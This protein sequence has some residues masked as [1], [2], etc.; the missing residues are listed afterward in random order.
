ML[1]LILTAVGCAL[2]LAGCER[3]ME[4]PTAVAPVSDPMAAATTA[5][6]EQPP[7]EAGGEPRVMVYHCGPEMRLVAEFKGDGMW[8][9]LPEQ[10]LLLQ[11][12]VS[13]SGARYEA[14]GV[15]FWNK[16]DNA[17]LEIEGQPQPQCVAEPREAVWEKAKLAG[18]DFRAIGQEPGWILELYPERVVLLLDYGQTRI[19]APSAS[20]INETFGSRFDLEAEGQ[21][22]TIS[23]KH[24]SCHDSMSGELF[25]TRVTI[26]YGERL[27]SGCGRSL[28]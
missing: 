13:A 8:L 20:P 1:R 15:L 23:L 3:Q 17:I 16:G 4:V 19:E 14:D 2:L 10:T 21:S 7:L 24:E 12:V 5:G 6:E 27:L 26:E 22:L 25:E 18:A 28:N 9:F 11:Q